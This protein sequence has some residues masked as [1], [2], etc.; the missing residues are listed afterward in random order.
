[1]KPSLRRVA[2]AS[3]FGWE[4]L[5]LLI[6]PAYSPHRGADD[7]M[8]SYIEYFAMNA[9]SRPYTRTQ[10]NSSG[11]SRTWHNEAVKKMGAQPKGLPQRRKAATVRKEIKGVRVCLSLGLGAFARGRSE[12][13]TSELQS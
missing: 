10:Q 6:M 11:G 7:L 1:P 12:E 3:S 8:S 2:L 13:H 9:T 4:F 5:I